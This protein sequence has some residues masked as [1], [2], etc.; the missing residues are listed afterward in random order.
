MLARAAFNVDK[1]VTGPE[2]M[3]YKI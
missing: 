1:L 2:Y 3:V